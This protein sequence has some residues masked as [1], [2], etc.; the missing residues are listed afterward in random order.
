[1]YFLKL[2]MLDGRKVIQLCLYCLSIFLIVITI[3][4]CNTAQSSEITDAQEKKRNTNDPSTTVIRLDELDLQK[5]KNQTK[6]LS[7]PISGRIISGN[8]SQL[9]SEVQGKIL[10][11]GKGFKKGVSYHNGEVM[12]SIDSK[13]YNLNLESQRS[14][15]LNILVGM[16]PDL[17]A[18][19][20]NNYSNWLT[21]IQ[22]FKINEALPPLP[23]T[24]SETEKYYVAS[25]QV[26]TNYYAIKAQEERLSKYLI[27]APYNCTIIETQVDL[28]GLVSPGQALATVMNRNSYELEAG[29][30]VENLSAIQVG[31][32]MEFSSNELKGNW[33]GQVIRIAD[34][35][36]EKTQNITVY[37]SLTGSPMKAGLYL[38]GKLKAEKYENVYSLHTSTITRNNTVRVLEND[39]IKTKKITPVAFHHD[40]VYVQDLTDGDQV[41]TNH[42]PTPVEGKKVIQ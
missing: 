32:T 13:E 30:R 3:Y 36:D 8:Q 5:V 31:K 1:M 16:M 11:T 24:K 35:I 28:G 22:N 12:L 42:F 18:D 19:Y 26:Y 39:I 14:N 10:S 15:L 2:K 17:K 23:E 29:V 33:S 40:S 7:I 34:L 6:E 21:Y 38:E 4:S 20:G 41:I 27:L 37:F 25:N 9:F